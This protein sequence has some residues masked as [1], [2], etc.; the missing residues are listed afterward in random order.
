VPEIR[1]LL[2]VMHWDKRLQAFG[3]GLL[4]L[5]GPDGRLHMDLRAASTKT[6]RCSGSRP[7]VQQMPVDVRKA[8]VVPPWMALVALDYGQIELRV[9]GELSGDEVL[10]QVFRDGQDIHRLNAEHFLGVRLEDL[11]ENERAI[12]RNKA[13]RISFGTLFG[14]GARGLA[15]SCWSAFRIEMT[16]AEA[17]HWKLAF[18]QRYPR[19]RQWQSEMADL[20][21]ATGVLR[22]VAGRPIKAAWERGELRWPVTCNF[23]VQSSSADVMLRAMARAHEALPGDLILQIHDELVCEVPEDQADQV[24]ADLTAIMS[25]S[26]VH[27][28]PTAPV[29]GLVTAKVV[30]CWADA[31]D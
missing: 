29:N 18:Y 30:Q 9:A 3:H 21:R 24:A 19:L 5:I 25:E 17:E 8:V 11:P 14:S 28:F 12:A 6:G 7:N 26:F 22:S 31:K 20:A 10:R 27:F 2:E 1:P 13:K 23:P 15:A 4:D 16:E